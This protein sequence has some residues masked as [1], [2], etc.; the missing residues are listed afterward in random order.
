METDDDLL[1]ESA[2]ELSSLLCMSSPGAESTQSSSYETYMNV[3]C[4]TRYP[5]D[6]VKSTGSLSISVVPSVVAGGAREPPSIKKGAAFTRS[7]QPLATGR[8]G[9][10]Q[11]SCRDT[12]TGHYYRFHC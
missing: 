4:G 11:V 7:S 10:C 2:S 8:A 9:T 12:V 3:T 1:L 6:T 5:T